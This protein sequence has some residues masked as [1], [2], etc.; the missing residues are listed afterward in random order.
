MELSKKGIALSLLASILFAC[1]PAYFLWLA[2]L[3]SIQILALRI[4]GTFFALLLLLFVTKQAA[5]FQTTVKRL[6]ANPKLILVLVCC[7]FMGAMHQGIFVWGPFSG[8]MLEISLGYFL[9]PL[10]L[11]LCGR[12]FYKETMRPLQSLA[13]ISAVLG[14]AHQLWAV[15]SLSWVTLII[16]TTY[17]LYIMLRRWIQIPPITGYLLEMGTLLPLA[18]VIII[19]T[20][21][22]TLFMSY[23]L[24][25]LLTPGL[26]LL[27]AIALAAL[28]AS[29]KLLPVILFGILSYVEPALLFAFAVLILKE[30]LSSTDMWTYIPIWLAILFVIIDSSAILRKQL[31]NK[32][33]VND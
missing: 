5:S 30:P 2:P 8:I 22:L 14:V 13:V 27:T 15:H 23:P 4:F 26:G 32:V 28:L 3:S 25:W 19:Y 33:M 31:G 17:P 7:A 1:L 11:I 21:P 24:L 6:L 10:V 29:S 16:A 18:I 20:N 9:A 12:L